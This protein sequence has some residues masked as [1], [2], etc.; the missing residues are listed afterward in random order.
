MTRDRSAAIDR[1]V[2]AY[3][4]LI[5]IGTSATAV[6]MIADLI[7]W[8][9]Q[10][11]DEGVDVQKLLDQALRRSSLL[12]EERESSKR[13]PESVME[14]EGGVIGGGLSDFALRAILDSA[15]G[16]STQAQT[17]APAFEIHLDEE[18]NVEF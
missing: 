12:E 13:E 14:E 9:K 5:R 16:R 1:A 2:A 4:R 11:V 6:E 7:E 3:R 18:G 8:H 10:F 15:S 17:T